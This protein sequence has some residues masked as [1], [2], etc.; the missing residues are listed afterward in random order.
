MMV[1]I[2]TFLRNFQNLLFST[3]AIPI[4]VPTSVYNVF[5]FSTSLP[6]FAVCGLFDNRRSD[7]CEVTSH[8]GFSLHFSDD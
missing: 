2:F 3:G 1:S 8:C 6:T 5:L 7:R 4:Y